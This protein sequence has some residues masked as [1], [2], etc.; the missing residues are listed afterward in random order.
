MSNLIS[1]DYQACGKS[2]INDL[3]S[4]ISTDLYIDN[5]KIDLNSPK[6]FQATYAGDIKYRDLNDIEI[7]HYR[8]QRKIGDSNLAN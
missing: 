6:R 1:Y 8:I 5:F 4:Y 3:F 2:P 7:T